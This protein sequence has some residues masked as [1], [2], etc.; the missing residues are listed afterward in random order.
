[1][2]NILMQFAIFLK[3][4]DGSYRGTK[5]VALKEISDN[6]MEKCKEQY[7]IILHCLKG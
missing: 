7:V 4:V 1:M 3:F 6:A 5:L 2:G